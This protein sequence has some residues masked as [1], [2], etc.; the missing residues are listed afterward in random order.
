MGAPLPLGWIPLGTIVY[1]FWECST[2]T[3]PRVTFLI[4]SAVHLFFSVSLLHPLLGFLPNKQLVLLLFSQDM[5]LR[6][7]KPRQAQ[8]KIISQSPCILAE[9]PESK[10]IEWRGPMKRCQWLGYQPWEKIQRLALVVPK[11]QNIPDCEARSLW[12]HPRGVALHSFLHSIWLSA[13]KTSWLLLRPWSWG[14]GTTFPKPRR[15]Q[16]TWSL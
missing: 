10:E 4:S 1:W 2:D 16:L 11:Y 15:S 9:S 5:L 6:E 8:W 3:L 7:T 12:N 13:W 14:W